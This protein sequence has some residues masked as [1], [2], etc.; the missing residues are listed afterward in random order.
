ML[1]AN[2]WLRKNQMSKAFVKVQRP[3]RNSEFGL[4][5]Q[6]DSGDTAFETFLISKIS[7]RFSE[8]PAILIRKS[9]GLSKA[10][11]PL[12]SATAVQILPPQSIFAI[13]LDP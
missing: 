4:R 7:I 8:A 13:G 10:V 11:S 12:R 1:R 6:S 2:S 3:H 9:S 5:W